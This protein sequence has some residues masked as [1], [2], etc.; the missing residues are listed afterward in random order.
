MRV[1]LIPPL[2][3]GPIVKE[4][5]QRVDYGC[6]MD[7]ASYMYRPTCV[8]STKPAKSW[9]GIRVHPSVGVTLR[10]VNRVT[11]NHRTMLLLFIAMDR[12]CSSDRTIIIPCL[13]PRVSQRRRKNPIRTVHQRACCHYRCNWSVVNRWKSHWPNRWNMHCYVASIYHHYHKN[14]LT[15]IGH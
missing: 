1:R 13:I 9:P 12:T 8:V 14:T 2:H 10:R 11:L 3:H 7:V 5:I 15:I 6:T 4:V